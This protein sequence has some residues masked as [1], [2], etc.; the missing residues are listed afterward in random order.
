NTST[1]GNLSYNLYDNRYR[2]IRSYESNHLGGFI[3]KDSKLNF[4]GL[5][6]KVT[7]TTKYNSSATQYSY[8]DNF[9]YDRRDRMLTH[10]QVIGS[11]EEKISTLSYDPLGVL[12][13]KKVGGLTG[14]LQTVDFT[15][16]IR[17]WMTHMNKDTADDDL[18]FYELN[19]NKDSFVPLYNGNISSNKYF[20]KQDYVLRGYNYYYDHLN[21]LVN[22]LSIRK[23]GRS[24]LED[25]L[26]DESLSYDKNGN[27]LTLNRNT[28][29]SNLP[30]E[31]DNLT[32]VYQGNQLLKVSDS[33]GS[34]SGFKDGTNTGN[35]YSYDTF[36]NIKQDLNK[37]LTNITYNHLNLPVE[38][39]FANGSKITYTYDAAGTRK[40]KRVQ[41]TAG[42]VVTTDYMNEFQYENSQLQFIRHPEGYVK[43]NGS[44]QF[45]YVYQYKDHLGNVR[46]S[47]ADIDGS[48]TIDS[49]SEIL[50]ENNYYP[51]GLKHQGYNEIANNNRS[52]AAEKY[53]YG[54]KEWNDELGLDL[55]DFHARNYDPAIGRWL[56]VDP[57]VEET[58][59]PY[60]Y[61]HNNPINLI[62]PDGRRATPS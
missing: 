50:E 13:Q 46:L 12:I 51:F 3:Q 27:I 44:G 36:G 2:P 45:M 40:S 60:Q 42:A 15:Y 24:I 58:M 33:S 20:T 22:A 37:N 54:G 11:R 18:F 49:A 8:V 41:P 34:P 28:N 62:D 39:T 53:K 35:D 5:P 57:L 14:N 7:T 56:N 31:I 23:Y 1:S 59:T 61:V 19:Y 9:T 6:S 47:Y 48:E 32:Y 43:H 38:I 29:L 21:R 52:E 30:H 4:T 55:Y 17:G 16:N 25:N 10:T 26:Y